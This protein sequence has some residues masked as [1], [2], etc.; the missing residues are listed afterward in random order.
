MVT[1]SL[2]EAGVRAQ[3]ATAI[4]TVMP[5]WESRRGLWTVLCNMV[6]CRPAV[7]EKALAELKADLEKPHMARV[8]GAPCWLLA[9]HSLNSNS[10]GAGRS[11]RLA[12]LCLT[13]Y[14]ASGPLPRPCFWRNQKMLARGEP[15][16][17]FQVVPQ[18]ATHTPRP[19]SPTTPPRR[20]RSTPSWHPRL[21]ASHRLPRW[22]L[23]Q[24]GRSGALQLSESTSPPG[25]VDVCGGC[26][27]GTRMGWGMLAGRQQVGNRVVATARI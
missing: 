12:Y 8:P 1:G 9:A 2:A 3:A 11:T 26:F 7:D 6:M 13:F 14:T 19:R 23:L 18:A 4:C 20:W 27:R 21:T 16:T 25:A 5:I 24:T 17:D 10:H 15:Q 22:G